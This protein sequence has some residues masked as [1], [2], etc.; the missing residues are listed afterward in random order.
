MFHNR[1]WP[2][3]VYHYTDF[4]ALEGIL[5][6]DGI[7]LCRSDKMND[8]R[9]L[10]NFIDL[11]KQSVSKRFLDN[12]NVLK[13][14]DQYFSNA[15]QGRKDEICYLTRPNPNVLQAVTADT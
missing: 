13:E 5:C 8:R 15:R 11:L 10:Y 2:Q 4:V 14:I 9:E 6:G 3:T 7:R 1:H 12:E